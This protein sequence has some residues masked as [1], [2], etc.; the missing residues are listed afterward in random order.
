MTASRQQRQRSSDVRKLGKTGTYTYFIT[1]PRD[2]I[3]TLGWRVG[4]KLVVERKGEQF[5]ISDWKKGKR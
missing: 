1:L 3:A 4:Q 5:V 2:D